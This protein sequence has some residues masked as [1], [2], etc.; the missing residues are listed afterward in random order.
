[1]DTRDRLVWL[2]MQGVLLA[3]VALVVGVAAGLHPAVAAGLAVGLVAALTV[4]RHRRREQPSLAM[5]PEYATL[6][7]RAL[8]GGATVTAVLA[9][10]W[11]WKNSAFPLLFWLFWAA[12]TAAPLLFRT[13]PFF[14]RAALGFGVVL[15]V[16]GVVGV[17]LCLF[18]FLPGAAVLLLVAAIESEHGRLRQGLVAAAAAVVLVSI[19][20][21]SIALL[22]TAS[23]TA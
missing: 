14:R 4:A 6:D 16:L 3:L 10:V 23:S 8:V 5:H 17:L 7:A 15:G 20:G 22:N 1:M 2:S 18:F 13:L 19:A 12:L 21:W 11:L 9:A